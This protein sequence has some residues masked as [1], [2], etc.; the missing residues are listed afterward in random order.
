M[1]DLG[2][3]TDASRRLQAQDA[4]PGLEKVTARLV[5]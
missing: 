2:R 3:A 4:L 5:E 1:V